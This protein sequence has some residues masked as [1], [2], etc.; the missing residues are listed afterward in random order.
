MTE[1]VKISP[2]LTSYF[3]DSMITFTSFSTEIIG[4]KIVKV[5][6]VITMLGNIIAGFLG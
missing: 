3:E 1:I 2:G 6:R 5:I 4:K